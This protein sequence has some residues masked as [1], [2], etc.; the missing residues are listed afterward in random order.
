M[1]A[2]HLRAQFLDQRTAI[3][4]EG[5]A[6]GDRHRHLRV[7]AMLQKI[8]AQM[9]A[10]GAFAR[11]VGRGRLVAKEVQVQRRV[12]LRANQRHLG[13]HLRGAQ[14]GAGQGGETAGLAHGNRHGMQAGAGHRGL[15]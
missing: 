1:K 12:A 14:H 4:V 5:V 13:A 11:R 7:Q 10:P 6:A 15:Q 3:C 9:L 2:H 8:G